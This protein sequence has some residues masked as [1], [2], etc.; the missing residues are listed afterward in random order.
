MNLNT[1][2]RMHNTLLWSLRTR[3]HDCTVRGVSNGFSE[4]TWFAWGPKVLCFGLGSGYSITHEWLHMKNL[5]DF[6]LT[7]FTARTLQ[8]NY[9]KTI[10]KEVFIFEM[11]TSTLSPNFLL[12]PAFE[13]LACAF[14]LSLSLL[15]ASGLYPSHPS[16]IH[17]LFVEIHLCPRLLLAQVCSLPRCRRLQ[18]QKDLALCCHLFAILNFLNRSLQFH[19]T[20]GP[21]NY[22]D[23]PTRRPCHLE[24]A[25]R[26]VQRFQ[27]WLHFGTTWT[28]EILSDWMGVEPKLPGDSNAQP[29]HLVGEVVLHEWFA[30]HREGQRMER[31]HSA[32]WPEDP[33]EE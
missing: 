27:P 33:V 1:L 15:N 7:P 19:F 5:S 29:K 6:R 12:N 30:N 9:L 13:V 23:G 21:A 24:M 8:L 18:V 20:P 22:V 14:L 25:Y 31:S 17:T 3:Q 2:I 26:L 10:Y 11:P 28:L 32:R 16:P 4:G